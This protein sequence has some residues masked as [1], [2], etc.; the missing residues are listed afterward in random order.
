MLE[1]ARCEMGMMEESWEREATVGE[2]NTKDAL[3][4]SEY[5]AL[6]T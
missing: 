6:W 5:L 2:E 1:L 3:L 4:L